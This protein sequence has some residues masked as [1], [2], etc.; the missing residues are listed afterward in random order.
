[1][2]LSNKLQ[3]DLKEASRELSINYTDFIAMAHEELNYIKAFAADTSHNTAVCRDRSYDHRY[4]L[5]YALSKPNCV[6]NKLS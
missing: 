5:L 1:M 4:S 2:R 6:L 3:Q